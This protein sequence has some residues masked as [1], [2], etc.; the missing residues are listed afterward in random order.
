V[1]LGRVARSAY[2][3]IAATFSI[4]VVRTIILVLKK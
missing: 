4:F 1:R 2:R 3:A